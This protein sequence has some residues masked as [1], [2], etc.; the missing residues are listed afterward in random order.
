MANNSEPLY[1]DI[2]E[3]L[4]KRGTCKVAVHP[5]LQDRVIHAVINKKYYDSMYKFSLA[6]RN[7]R[8]KITYTKAKNQVVFTLTEY[9]KF[10]SLTSG[11]I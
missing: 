3:A 9:V 8:S 5:A 4:K 1:S 11:D 6:E 2:W 7:R 10:S